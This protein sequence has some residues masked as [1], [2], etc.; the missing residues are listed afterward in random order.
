[1]KHF[2]AILA[3]SF[4]LSAEALVSDAVGSYNEGTLQDAE[5]L[6]ESGEGYMQLYRDMERIWGTSEMITMIEATG[7]DMNS[8]YP[9]KDRL[10]VEDISVKHGGDIS[11][12]ASHENGLDVDIQFY[13]LDGQE[14]V[15]NGQG[16]YRQFAAPMVNKDG[17]LSENFDVERNWELMKSLFK[18][19]HVA[20]IFIDEKIKQALCQYANSKNELR[21]YA[22][23]LRNMKHEDNHADHLHVRMQCPA[24]QRRCQG[25]HP[26]TSGP[27]GCRL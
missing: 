17:S 15:S 3:L 26:E 2:I 4:T 8:R 19:G 10:Q 23:V 6:Q 11:G 5:C 21:E 9:G 7:R 22:T 1:M 13:K 14:H 16:A 24:G 12:H 18:N 27:T 20:R 25:S